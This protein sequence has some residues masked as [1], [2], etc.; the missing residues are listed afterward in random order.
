MLNYMLNNCV[1]LLSLCNA[2][3]KC[4]VQILVFNPSEL[5][6]RQALVVYSVFVF[7][8]F[9][10]RC[11]F[12]DLTVI[13]CVDFLSHVSCVKTC[14]AWKCASLNFQPKFFACLCN[15]LLFSVGV[16]Q[17]HHILCDCHQCWSAYGNLFC[18]WQK[19]NTIMSCSTYAENVNIE[20]LNCFLGLLN[21][22][23]HVALMWV[24]SLFPFS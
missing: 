24:Q 16:L 20:Q 13:F 14:F 23:T 4:I 2:Q 8:T 5:C 3:C 12:L 1:D 22:Q 11:I 15:C 18:E 9:M 19:A 10:Y 21:P 7:C 17:F 6:S